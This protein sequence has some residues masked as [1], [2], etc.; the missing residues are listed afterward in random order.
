MFKLEQ[1]IY[2]SED[3]LWSFIAFPDNED[4]LALIDAKRTGILSLL[5]EKCLVP[6][7]TDSSFARSLY[8]KCKDHGRFGATPIQQA[9]GK[10]SVQ[11]YA[12]DVVYDT[13]GFLE[14]NTDELGN[15][16]LVVTNR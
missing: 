5:D 8:S 4:V 1:D 9:E 3:I 11:H 13:V 16:S 7:A 2:E 12:R 15:A 10:F 6:K 14:K